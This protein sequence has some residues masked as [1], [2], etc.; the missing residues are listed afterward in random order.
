MRVPIRV[1]MTVWYVALFAVVVAVVGVFVVTRLR[2]DLTDSIDRGLVP[3]VHQVAGDVREEGVADFA[4]SAAAVPAGERPAAQVVTVGGAVLAEH[5][6]P[7]AGLAMVTAGDIAAARAARGRAVVVT[8]SLPPGG[9]AFRIAARTVPSPRAGVVVVVAAESL[10]PVE[11]SVGRLTLLLLVAGPVALVVAAVAGWAL[12]GR[13]LR[14]VTLMT[15]GA[16][17]VGVGR[18]DERLTVPRTRDEVARL[19]E[20]LNTMLG[21]IQAGVEQ[22]RRL[23]ADA[24][25]ELRAPLAAMRAEIDVSLRTDDHS[26]EGRAAL[27]SLR[28]EVDRM[29]GTVR[30]LL[31]LA[32]VDEGSPIETGDIRLGEVVAGAIRGVSPTAVARGVSLIHEQE[33]VPVRGDAVRL[34]HAIRNVLVNAVAF[35]PTG[36]VVNVRTFIHDGCARVRV[37]DDGPGVP[38]EYRARV[39]ERFVRVDP[40]RTRATGGS[41]LGLAIT[42][43]LVAAHGGS[44]WMEQGDRGAIVVIELPVPQAESPGG[45]PAVTASERPAA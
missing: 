17:C 41:G 13:A 19:G 40:S 38:E 23:V 34:D 37:E 1:R 45:Q 22:Q 28:E 5:G 9:Q 29:T 4:D 26:P 8:H 6:D 42:R 2:A 18:L 20:A 32:A 25:H 31:T 16:E 33:P 7:V 12:A 3:A 10:G 43:D 35:S 36:G 44:V 39:F 11:R 30:D 14:P 21:R 15:L 24:S 27:V